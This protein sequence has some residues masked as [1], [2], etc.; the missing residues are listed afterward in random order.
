MAKFRARP[1]LNELAHGMDTNGDESMNN[2]I[3]H[4]APKN[5]VH[6]ATRSLTPT[7]TLENR[8]AFAVGVT[9]LG[10]KPH[11]GRLFAAFDIV[12]TTPVLHHL[13]VKNRNGIKRLQK[14]KTRAA[15][16]ARMKRK[17]EVSR[18]DEATAKKERAKRDGTHQ[19]GGNMQDG[20][21][22]GVA[23]TAT[24]RKRTPNV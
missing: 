18:Q 3:L 6:C 10:F 2:T 12:L 9:T 17:I 24:E 11:F 7:L 23:L 4:C 13:E 22:D 15:K 19:S 5:G 14:R 21:F 16:K 8:V 20:G 1:R